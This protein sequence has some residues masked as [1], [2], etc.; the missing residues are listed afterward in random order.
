[1]VNV[2]DIK[3]DA[4]TIGDRLENI[5]QRQKELMIRYS[6]IEKK[7]NFVF[8]EGPLNLDDSAHQYYIKDFAWRITEE[9]TEAT[10][11]RRTHKD[12]THFREELCDALHF[13][14]ELLILVDIKPGDLAVFNP[15]K[16]RLTTL[17]EISHNLSIKR[18][19]TYSAYNVIES[20]GI[21]MNL[22]K[23]K[24]W[25]LTHILT[26]KVTFRHKL[27]ATFENFIDLLTDS[28][29]SS[30]KLYEMYFKK[31]EVNKFRQRSNY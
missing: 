10:E 8:P 28:E 17:Y 20:L 3:I 31:S 5:F 7:N 13:L 18:T 26:D 9:I 27:I 21:A 11:A 24:P 4:P 22:L 1:M 25:K 14:I 15:N 19:I 12:Q 30:E 23:L 2:D 16:D 6:E 29:I